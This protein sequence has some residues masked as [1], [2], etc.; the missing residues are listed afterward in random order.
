MSCPPRRWGLLV[1][2]GGYKPSFF[3][4]SFKLREIPASP[5]SQNRWFLLFKIC[6]VNRVLSALF[7]LL[8]EIR[9]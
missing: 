5:F 6:H 3:F 1:S 2:N 9:M 4:F 7:K 8:N